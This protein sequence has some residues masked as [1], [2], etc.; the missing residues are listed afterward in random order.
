MNFVNI[1]CID[2]EGIVNENK[3]YTGKKAVMKA[4]LQFTKRLR[5]LNVDIE[6]DLIEEAITEGWYKY[7]NCTVFLSHPEVKK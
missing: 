6:K 3:L 4:E 1:I 7:N 5:E 2:E